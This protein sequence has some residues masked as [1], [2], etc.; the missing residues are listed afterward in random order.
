[1]F[2]SSAVIQDITRHCQAEP[3]FAM[4]YFYFDFNDLKKQQSR[5]LVR[6]LLTQFSVQ[7]SQCP[8]ALTAVYYQHLNRAQEPTTQS[9]LVALKQIIQSFQN[10]YI[11]ID[12]LDVCVDREDLFVFVQEVVEWNLDKLHILVTSRRERYIADCL[13]PLIPGPA[14]INLH[15]ELNGGDIRTY[16]RQRLRRD[17]KFHKWPPE[18]L[19]NIESILGD[20]ARGM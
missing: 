15:T 3:S 20:G 7:C 13:E 11:V 14:Q 18:E 6:S 8:E 4:A 19:A 9:L 10:A 5:Y 2:D 17:S 16:C 12:A 1:M